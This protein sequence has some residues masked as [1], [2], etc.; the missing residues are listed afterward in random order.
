VRRCRYLAAGGTVAG[1]AL[2]IADLGRPERFLNMLR[3]FKPGSPLNVGSWILSA[4]TGLSVAAAVLGGR[5]GRAEKLGDAAGYGAALTGM[6]LAGYTG[7]LLAG[8][9]VPAWQ[10]ARRSLPALFVA[11]AGS[12]AASLLSLMS[13]NRRE[14]SIVGRFGTIAEIAEI[15]AARALDKEV[16]RVERVARPYREGLSGSLWRASANLSYLGLALGVAARR[17]R[18]AQRAAGVVGAVG[19][20]V[21]RFAVFHAGTAS[22]HDPRATFELQRQPGRDGAIPPPGAASGAGRRGSRSTR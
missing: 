18:A 20:I 4:A 11:S 22:A 17:S 6:P 14:Q 13:L 15:A 7:V 9:A 21:T 1:T 2:L 19:G 8:T 16:G 3:V 5:G 10:E 12:S